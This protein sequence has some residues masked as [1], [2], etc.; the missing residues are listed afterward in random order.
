MISPFD[1]FMAKITKL[2]FPSDFLSK[3]IC[4]DAVDVMKKIPGESV[5]LVI[6]SPPYNLKNSTGRSEVAERLIKDR[7]NLQEE[8]LTANRV[9]L[10]G[11]E[12]IM[13][14]AFDLDHFDT[15]LAFGTVM[16]GDS[17]PCLSPI[18]NS[19]ELSL[20]SPNDMVDGETG[21]WKSPFGGAGC[22][23]APTAKRLI[24]VLA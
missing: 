1:S 14:L 9:G 8:L 20:K 24:P 5:H 18:S 21:G 23:V 17:I 12:L 19:W 7:A 22:V 16:N 3:I 10:T 15:M 2:K 11:E 6:T 13:L 4:G